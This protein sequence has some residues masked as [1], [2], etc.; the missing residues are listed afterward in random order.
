MQAKHSAALGTAIIIIQIKF[1]AIRVNFVPRVCQNV[2][3]NDSSLEE[4]NQF[5]EGTLLLFLSLNTKPLSK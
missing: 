4:L 3:N 1:L 2:L 5:S